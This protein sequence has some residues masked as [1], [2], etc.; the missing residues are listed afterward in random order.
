MVDKSAL[1]TGFEMA[2][3]N[4]GWLISIK[5]SPSVKAFIEIGA[6]L[7][8]SARDMVP[9][10]VATI[11]QFV[12]FVLRAEPGVFHAPLPLVRWRPDLRVE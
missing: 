1:S 10:V 3:G 8:I 12:P 7:V 2:V 5:G 6:D 11:L 4:H 9:A